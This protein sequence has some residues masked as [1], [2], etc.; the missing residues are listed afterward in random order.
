MTTKKWSNLK[1]KKILDKMEKYKTGQMWLKK[2]IKSRVK[3]TLNMVL[4]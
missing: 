3:K 1:I 2:K 4:F